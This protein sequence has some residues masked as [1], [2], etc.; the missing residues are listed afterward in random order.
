MAKQSNT[1]LR[2]AA[3]S[4]RFA[5]RRWLADPDISSWWG[6]RGS[7]EAEIALAMSNPTALCR[8]IECDGEA[9]GYAPAMALAALGSTHPPQLPPA[10]WRIELFIGASEHRGRGAGP[11]ALALMTAEVF[12][13]TL[14]VACCI[15]ASIKNER[16]VRACERGGFRWLCIWE[17]PTSGLCWVLV[18]DRPI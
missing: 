10:C 1:T 5:I 11:D 8:V 16:A 2:P 6:S 7:A 3:P 14:A 18:K 4:D 17:D 13:T 12:S 15:F 9:A